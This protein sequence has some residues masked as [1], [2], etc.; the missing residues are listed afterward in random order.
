MNPMVFLYIF[1]FLYIKLIF[2][3][4]FQSILQPAA[5][6]Q[7]ISRQAPLPFAYLEINYT[8]YFSIFQ[9]II[10]SCPPSLN[11]CSVCSLFFL[12]M[13]I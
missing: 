12:K 13:G 11:F 6:N 2:L 5:M 4:A 1:I 9:A 7:K 3:S 10:D 8:Q